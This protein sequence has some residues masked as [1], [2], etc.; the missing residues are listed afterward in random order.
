[1]SKWQ[2]R[3]PEEK[4]DFFK[5]QLGE[6]RASLSALP[7]IERQLKSYER[8]TEKSLEISHESQEQPTE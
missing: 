4:R 3:S 6:I 1:M 8:L 2:D 7:K 5:K